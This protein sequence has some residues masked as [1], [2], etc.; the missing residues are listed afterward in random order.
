MTPRGRT[1]KNGDC[2]HGPTNT[3]TVT[4]PIGDILVTS[5]PRGVHSIEQQKGITDDDFLP[6]VSLQVESVHQQWDDN[7]YT[8]KPAVTCIKWLKTYFENSPA[9]KDTKKPGV[10][11]ARYNEDSFQAKAWKTLAAEIGLGATVS[12]SDL[13]KMCG[14]PRGARAVGLAMRSNPLMLLVPCH[15]VIQSGGVPGNYCAGR[16]NKV[17]LW[18]LLHEGASL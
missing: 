16:R 4:S 13:A 18:L 3:Y 15:R 2:F 12:Y 17:K 9:L 11:L 7:G 1:H 6:N 14:C 10:C 5:C 8:Y